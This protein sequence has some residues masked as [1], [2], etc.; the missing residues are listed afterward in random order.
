MD[1]A[2]IQDGDR[3]F[4]LLAVWVLFKFAKKPK[5]EEKKR[6][7]VELVHHNDIKRVWPADV[8]SS[9]GGGCCIPSAQ[10]SRI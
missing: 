8:V 3:F 6:P 9:L 10:L 7:N 1:D 2:G 4:R 5:R